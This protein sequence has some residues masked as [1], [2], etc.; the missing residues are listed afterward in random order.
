MVAKTRFH[1][2]LE[3]KILQEVDNR[4]KS[5][6][7]GGASDYPHYRE[8]VGYITGLQAALALCEEIEREFE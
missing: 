2:L 3:E 4:S 8:N 6:A 5:I 7:S 1:N